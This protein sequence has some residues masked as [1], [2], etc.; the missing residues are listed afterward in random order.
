MGKQNTAVDNASS[1][2][3]PG[4]TSNFQ[5]GIRP[6]LYMYSRGSSN[7]KP[8]PLRWGAPSRYQTCASLTV[9]LHPAMNFAVTTDAKLATELV[10]ICSFF[11]VIF[12]TA[13]I[14][15]SVSGFPSAF[16][17]SYRAFLP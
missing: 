4:F 17:K 11:R 3:S 13:Q 5:L 15:A 14:S 6:P 9:S 7:L 12:E 8:S 10:L 2:L 1:L 16:S